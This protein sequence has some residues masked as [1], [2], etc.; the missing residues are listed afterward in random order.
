VAGLWT[1]W[2]ALVVVAA[3]LV[4]LAWATALV[5][6]QRAEAAADLSALAAAQALVSGGEPCPAGHRVA[7]SAG[8]RLVGCSTTGTAVTVVVEVEA[9]PRAVLGLDVPPARA[10]ARAGVPP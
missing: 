10:R 2:A 3:C 1:V 9:P 6:R 7:D 8:A 5:S 4:V